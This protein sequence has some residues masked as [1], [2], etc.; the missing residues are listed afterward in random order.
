MSRK[1]LTAAIAA[2]LAAPMAA[3][4]VDFTISGQI[5]RALVII[6][7]DAGTS[8]A[9]RDNGESSSRV[10]VGGNSE[11]ADGSTVTIQF[12]YEVAGG[13]NDA[14]KGVK[15]RHANIK[16]SGNFGGVTI[17]QGSE[18]GDGSQYSDT[19]GVV[20]IGQGSLN[21]MG[22]YFGSLDSG[23]R[24]N[25]IRYDSPALGPISAAVSVGN[26]D[27]VSGRLKL[28]TEVAGSTF[29]AQLGTQRTGGGASSIGASFG[30]TLA[31]G[32]TISGAWAQ[33]SDGDGVAGTPA[34]R[35]LA[36]TVDPTGHN[37]NT[38]LGATEKTGPRNSTWSDSGGGGSGR[39]GW[40]EGI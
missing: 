19:T 31:S 40:G 10:R 26:N 18:A 12:E 9:V 22:D 38:V 28:S 2:A 33:G 3:Q 34:S 36:F 39:R 21:T 6:D 17:G 16:Y 23:G 4:A 5:N 7:N 37:F 15:L 35:W 30:S 8:A 20:G 32:L 1:A 11:L 27:S 29:G 25:M 24:T 13:L 14:T